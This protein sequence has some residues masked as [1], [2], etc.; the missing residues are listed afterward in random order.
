MV[1]VGVLSDADYD[2]I[3]SKIPRRYKG[4]QQAIPDVSN[5]NLS[6]T[7]PPPNA[8]LSVPSNEGR[9]VP[10]TPSRDQSPAPPA[11]TGIGQAEA[12]Y[13]FPGTDSGD[14]G[15]HAGEKIVILEY[16]NNG[17]PAHFGL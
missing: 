16:V 1:D 13:D 5:L 4:N 9:K 15:F 11:Y 2:L 12:L 14:L 3:T 7:V 10:P 6:D 17:R 8:S